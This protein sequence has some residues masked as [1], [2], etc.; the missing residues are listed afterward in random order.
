MGVFRTN[1][2]LL[3]MIVAIG[4]GVLVSRTAPSHAHELRQHFVLDGN[5]PKNT[6]NLNRF[7][8]RM[9]TDRSIIIPSDVVNLP[10]SEFEKVFGTPGPG[11]TD[12][13]IW[14]RASFL[15]EADDSDSKAL[16]YLEVGAT[17]LND[18]QMY[19]LSEESGRTIWEG[20]VGDRIPN[21]PDAIAGL[22]HIAQW[23]IL[24]PGHYWLVMAVRT[25]SSHVFEVTLSP[26][27]VVIADAGSESYLKGSYLGILLV[28]FGVYLTF[29]V[30]TR[31]RA[32][33]WYAGYILSLFLINL[34]TSGYA[35]LI[36][37]D[38]W[39][40]AS[41]FVT[42]TG[43]ALALGTSLAM[44]ASIVELDRHNRFLY[45]VMMCFAGVAMCGFLTST[46]DL[47]IYF[48]KLFFVP[49]I[50]LLI[51]LLVYFV[52]IGYREKRLARLSFLLVALGVPTL[53]V[54][55]HLLM[56]MG[57]VPINAFTGNIYSASSTVHLVMV[58]LA[59]GYRT[60]ALANRRMD[61]FQNSQRANQLAG[62][63]RTFITMLSHEFRTPLAI[64]QR[65]AEI[66]GL[67][68]RD[69]QEAVHTRLATIRSNAGQLSGLVD[70][71]LT[72]ETLDSATFT[73]SRQP[74]A[75][76]LFLSEL[77]ARRTREVPEQNVNLINSEF[78]IVEVDRILLE[79]AIV[80]LIENARKYAPGSPV[81]IA[82]NRAANGFVYIRVLDEGPG[83]P[84]EDLSNVLNAFY[85]GR[86]SSVT[87][88]VGLG[89]HITNQIVEAHEGTLSVSVGERGGTT[90]LLKIPYNH[91]A[92]IART[93]EIYLGVPGKFRPKSRGED[94]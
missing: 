29:G 93:N 85:R 71:F 74:V 22:T 80:N 76:D 64:I 32:I 43:T 8:E 87:Q 41:D 40:L 61:A 34:G 6:V 57:L 48:A 24:S 7:L 82:C 63:Q 68:L 50:F 58:A 39:P 89:L 65:S 10:D 54:I 88:G 11:Y 53:A 30:L 94:R 28:A 51:V 15:V 90:I 78:A 21:G 77:I 5:G 46:S 84:P 66:L 16:S 19:V 14:Y 72:K 20:R 37:K 86:E 73:T 26:E 47:Y 9:I 56:L 60:Y 67:H 81:W 92:T 27:S 23:P 59:M 83:I 33:N 79:R 42:G 4:C 62:E 45:R 1:L 52:M 44:W 91:E 3:A 35:Q 55:V 31:D 2:A 36:F 17:Y 69:E 38:L 49:D 13:T 18:I 75:I 12:R 70:A 25:N